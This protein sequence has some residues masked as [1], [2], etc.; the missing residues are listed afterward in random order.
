M[1]RTH[2]L[3]GNEELDLDLRPYLNVLWRKR[4]II[5]AVTA[6]AVIIAFVFN[7]LVAPVYE[8]VA[9]I[10]VSE[11][12]SSIYA[13]PPAAAQ[14]LTSTAFLVAGARSAGIEASDRELRKL[15]RAEPIRETRM[16]RLRVRYSDSR[17]AHRFALALA[18]AFISRASEAVHLRRKA[19]QIRLDA[20]NA[21]LKE[22]QH[23]LRLTRET[24][25][26]L[27][28]GGALNDENRGFIRSFTLSASGMSESLY[29]ELQDAQRSLTL[30]L[31]ALEL[32]IMIEVPAVSSHPIAPRKTT[33]AVL[34][35]VLG[36]IA[37]AAAA[38]LIDYF[39]PRMLATASLP[40]VEAGSRSSSPEQAEVS[41]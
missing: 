16:V 41:N 20:L 18:N 40:V 37:G 35:A 31:L 22:V 15:V 32:P 33:N 29:S 2:Q 27:Q 17:K 38:L 5:G 13:T 39:S 12:G 28:R 8:S 7:T 30:E 23:V 34:A 21:Q 1:D 24:L 19:A 26:A 3:D 25:T 36:L 10:H 6:V 11:Q 9:I 4:A 14:V